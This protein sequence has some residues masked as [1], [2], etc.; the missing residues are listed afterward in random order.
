ML[1]PSLTLRPERPED[2]PFI[3]HLFAESRFGL[4]APLPWVPSQK[5]VFLHHQFQLQAAHYRSCYP[6]AVFS[7]VQ[8]QD[9]PIGRFYVNRTD[10]AIRV[11]DIT[12]A[13]EHQ[14]RGIGGGLLRI[15]LAEAEATGRPVRLNVERSNPAWRLYQRLGFRKIHDGGIYLEM[16]WSPA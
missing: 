2:E 7:I 13:A 5:L 8:L 12:L 15:L 10:A 3:C 4:V 6:D 11:I 9:H 1:E 14:N 16:E